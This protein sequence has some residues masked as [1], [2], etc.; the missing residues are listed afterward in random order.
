MKRPA[1][2]LLVPLL[3]AVPVLAQDNSQGAPDEVLK[4]ATFSDGTTYWHGDCKP[5]GS[6]SQTDFVTSASHE[7]GLMV[8]LHSTTWTKVTQEIR[9]KAAPADS[10]LTITYQVSSDFK[11]S[12]RSEDYIKCGPNVGFGGAKIPSKLG[13]ILA[14]IDVP[15]L[16]R[17]SVAGDGGGNALITI[18]DDNVT[19]ANFAPATAQSPQTFTVQMRP[20]PPTQD[21]HQTFCLAFPPGSGS[22]TF[23]KI[24]LAPGTAGGS[25]SNP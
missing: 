3:A 11:L 2:F 5:A 25:S 19:F 24:S 22:I 14:F 13:N 1:L 8:E 12:D 16:Q 21:S 6:D 20:P 9:G 10:V 15:P 17:S 23:T 18:Y 7:A 4:N